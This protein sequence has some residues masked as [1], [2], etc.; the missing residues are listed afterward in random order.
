MPK[1]RSSIRVSIGDK[2]RSSGAASC[3]RTLAGPRWSAL[4]TSAWKARIAR[5]VHSAGTGKRSICDKR[6]ADCGAAITAR[7]A[8]ATS[9]SAARSS[10]SAYA[11]ASAFTRAAASACTAFPSGAA[12]AS[13]SAQA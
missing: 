12:H 8:R 10:P 3:S 9:S 5:I 11:P 4:T 13:G 2:A 6:H 7:S 1:N